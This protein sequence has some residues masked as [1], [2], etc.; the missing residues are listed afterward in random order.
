MQNNLLDAFAD[1]MAKESRPVCEL[2]LT[3]TSSLSLLQ[4][5]FFWLQSALSLA[6][7]WVD[8]PLLLDGADRYRRSVTKMLLANL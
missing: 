1:L 8:D 7:F 5:S 6:A 2:R 3:D 4:T